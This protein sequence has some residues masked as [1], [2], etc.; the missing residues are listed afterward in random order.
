MLEEAALLVVVFSLGEVLEDYAADRARG[1][2]RALM[3]LVPPTATRRENGTTAQVRVEDLA[4]GDVVVV[5]PGERVP[6]DG[7]VVAGR[8][9]VDQSP[10][11]GESI[12]VEIGPGGR[13]GVRR[14]GEWCRGAGVRVDREYADTT[15][16]RIIRQVEEA[17]AHQGEAQR[18]AD[19]FGAI[20]TPAMFALAVGVAVGGVIAGGDAREWLY[21]ALVVLTVSCSCA[22]VISVPVSVVA[23]I[24]RAARDGILIKGGAHLETLG[25]VRAVALDKTGTLTWGRPQLVDAFGLDG[26]DEREVI[27]LAASVE[28]GS[29][30]PVAGAVVAAADENALERSV[31]AETQA[32][33]G[34]GVEATVGGRRLFVGRADGRPAIDDTTRRRL[35]ELEQK[36]KT[37]VVLA[38]EH[39]ALG[40][41]GIADRLRPDAAPA[42]RRLHHL[43]VD[44]TVMLTGDNERTAAAVA[45]AA[46]I[47]EYRARLLPEHK[48]E[49]VRELRGDGAV[50][51]IGDGINDA[52]ALATADVGI[53]MGAAGTDVALETADVALIADDLAKLHHAVELA[54][55]ALRNIR[56]NIALSLLTITALVAAA[57]SGA[58]TLT[59]GLLLNEGTAL[60]IIANGLR[61]L[62]PSRG[63]A[64]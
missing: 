28:A 11:T 60:V 47:D 52:P 27:A 46:G 25:R 32:I 22:L 2:I 21:R 35:D 64:S 12:P 41:L 51:M 43:G 37:V 56:E 33:P 59:S 42:V 44:R 40:V 54:R 53:A 14:N 4:L 8:S 1:S 57:R 7:E 20:Y 9:A 62:R 13:H 36:G 61:L 15:L 24:S 39:R 31:A 23:A 18:F 17:Q 5:R 45:A 55:G 29:E 38:D 49:A 3:E 30:H 63:P 48:T 58:L 50:A 19:R 26:V 16:A 34:V 10:V 6:T